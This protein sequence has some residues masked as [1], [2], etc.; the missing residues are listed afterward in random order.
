MN[1]V[2]KKLLSM[3]LVAMLLVSGVPFQAFAA[4][5]ETAPAV[6]AVAETAAATEAPVVETAAATEAPVVET[7]VATEAPVVET[8]AATE[9]P[10]VETTAPVV[11]TTEATEAPTETTAATEAPV[12]ETT[13]ATEAP[14]TTE[15]TEATEAEEKV[16]KPAD[17][18]KIPAP[19][20]SIILVTDGG[21]LPG[22]DLNS[23]FYHGITLGQ[24]YGYHGSLPI[25]TRTNYEFV[26]WYGYSSGNPVNESTIVTGNEMLIAKWTLTTYNVQFQRFDLSLGDWVNVENYNIKAFS[27][28]NTDSGFPTA[29]EIAAKYDLPYYTIV[30]WEIGT[31]D[32]AFHAGATQIT[33]D[34]VV[35]PRYQRSVE[36]N[37]NNPAGYTSS[38]SKYITVEIGE[39]VGVLPHPGAR[40]GFAFVDWVSQDYGTVISTKANLSNT[41]AHPQYNP[42][43]HGSVFY[44]RYE[45]STRVTL[46]IHTNGNTQTATKVVYY[47]DAPSQGAFDTRLINMYEIFPDYGYYDD[48]ND[49]AYGW[50]DAT[51]WKN[52]CANTAANKADVYYNIAANG[53][54]E[55]HI[56][57]INNGAASTGSNNNYNTNQSTADK[58][59]PTTGDYI[60][61]AGTVLA[62]SA[63]ALAVIF[64]M[65]K[66]KA[67]K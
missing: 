28:I 22:G 11:E 65:K 38:S 15:A 20:H 13:T 62:V 45:E 34:I 50:Y 63:A 55:L 39:S 47:Y 17:S 3:T 18:G 49:V 37:V 26:G 6:E 46:F 21:I 19:Q 42:A 24:T 53:Y 35:R 64:F 4:E 29:E 60:F 5:V 16:E 61:V 41:K 30:G 27:T 10:V 2:C 12:V 43:I 66:R 7:T 57:L 54:T 59:N 52:Y 67:A 31:S 56:M 14:E 9:A 40:D 8:T 33:K 1:T 36:L 44:A 32:E 58:T 25:P 48:S 51:Q 23:V